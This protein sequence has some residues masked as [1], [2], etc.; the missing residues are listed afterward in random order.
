M[1]MHCFITGI[2]GFIGSATAKKLLANGHTVSGLTSDKSRIESLHKQG[3]KPVL[4]DISQPQQWT[5]HIRDADAIIHLAT[6]PIP[7]R[8]GMRYVRNLVK[9]QRSVTSQMLAALSPNCKAFIYTSGASVYGSQQGIHEETA[10]LD[11]CRIAEPYAAGEQLAINAFHEKGIPAMVLRPAGV[12]GFGGVFGRFWSGPML[13]GKRTGIPGDGKQLFSFIHIEDCAGVFVRC[14]E[15]PMPGEI[16]NI[17]DDEPVPLG[18]MIRM[19]AAGLN[20]P[21]PFN[22]PS[23][24]FN[25]M[26]GPIVGELLLRNK[27]VNNRKMKEVLKAELRYPT[28]RD[29]IMALA[30]EAQIAP[31]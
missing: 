29:G 31:S 24:L 4:G 23:F 20:A 2:S 9:V 19:C 13:K 12:Y 8:P 22:I 21:K 30:K 28:Y 16:F 15:N 26:A 17:S 14:V 5:Q 11:P 6:L 25:M 7:S 10:M 27:T 18:I 3:F 1:S